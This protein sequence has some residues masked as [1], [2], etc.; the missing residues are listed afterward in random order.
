MS[1]VRKVV[2]G[3]DVPLGMA[4]STDT[5]IVVVFAAMPFC[6]ADTKLDGSTVFGRPALS[7][8]FVDLTPDV[9]FNNVCNARAVPSGTR[10][11]SVARFNN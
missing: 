11:V 3:E 10:S 8:M 4:A 5:L 2:R 7:M 1:L 6:A 9:M